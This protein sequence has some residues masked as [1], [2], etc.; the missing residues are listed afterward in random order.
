MLNS[1]G[2]LGILYVCADVPCCG[3]DTLAGG[4]VLA[5]CCDRLSSENG[6]KSDSVSILRLSAGFKL[7]E[8]DVKGG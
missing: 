4:V 8:L 5:L 1:S 7:S 2:E 6:L 3:V